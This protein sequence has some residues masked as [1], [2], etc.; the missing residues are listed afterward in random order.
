MRKLVLL[1]ALLALG[2][3]G[4]FQTTF[5]NPGVPEGEE[6]DPW[7]NFFMFGLAG[8]AEVDVRDFCPGEVASVGV[9]QNGGTWIVSLLTLGIYTPR[10]VYITCAAEG[11]AA[12]SAEIQLDADGQPQ[13]VSK[14]VG[15]Q[16]FEGT[17]ESL[18]QGKYR[19]ALREVGR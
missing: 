13:K 3:S 5:V 12:A 17:A 19:V 15:S 8:E 2:L 1:S 9:G 11:P 16:R 4:C 14:R 6:H 18:G 7:V 10:K